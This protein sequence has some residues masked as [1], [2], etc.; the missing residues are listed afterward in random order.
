MS[1][2]LFLKRFCFKYILSLSLCLA[3]PLSPSLPLPLSPPQV[4][5]LIL[6]FHRAEETAF[7]VREKELF[8]QFC[9]AYAEDLVPFLNRCLQVL[10]PPAQLAL[11]LGKY[12]GEG[13]KIYFPVLSAKTIQ[14]N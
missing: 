10:F 2:N 7:S 9:C 5:K 14:K 8:V 11:I 13:F 6:V 12:H 4:T 3:L 1:L